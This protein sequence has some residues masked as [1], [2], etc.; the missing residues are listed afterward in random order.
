MNG[1]TPTTAL[2]QAAAQASGLE[3]RVVTVLLSEYDALKAEQRSRIGFR[4][5]LLYAVLTAAAAIAAVTAT[6][7]RLELLLVLPLAGTVLGWTHLHNDHMITSI[8]RYVRDRL[9]PRLAGLVD[10]TDIPMFEWE[11]EHTGDRWRASRRRLQLAVNLGAFCLPPLAALTLI[12]AAGPHT[13]AVLAVS[14]AEL[15]VLI[16]LA[17]QIV[18]YVE[19]GGGAR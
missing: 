1:Q 12:W 6:A 10:A 5:Q 11:T 13:A 18:R 19:L 2:A 16:V 17:W 7:G 4:D 9:G 8:G 3:E 14:V 15:A